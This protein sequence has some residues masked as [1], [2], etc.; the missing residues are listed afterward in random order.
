MYL[1]KGYTCIW[2]HFPSAGDK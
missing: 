2:Y 1:L